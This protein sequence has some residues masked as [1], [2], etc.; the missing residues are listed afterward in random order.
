MISYYFVYKS[1]VKN[2]TAL[3]C[4]LDFSIPAD[5]SPKCVSGDALIHSPVVYD[6]RIID[7]Q[8]PLHKA[9]VWIWPRVY[10]F[11]IHFPPGDKLKKKSIKI[12]IINIITYC[13][14]WGVT[15][16]RHLVSNTAGEIS[17]SYFLWIFGKNPEHIPQ[18]HTLLR[19]QLPS[20]F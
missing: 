16:C 8:V 4:K 9:V 13:Y 7:Q 6:M 20:Y 1:R 3:T 18:G 5:N 11:P 2:G 12:F 17:F 15:S 14:L 19:L 10:F